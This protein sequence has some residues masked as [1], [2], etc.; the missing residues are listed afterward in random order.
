MI[1]PCHVS[2]SAKAN[3]YG[4]NS[5]LSTEKIDN[6]YVAPTGDKD[7]YSTTVMADGSTLDESERTFAFLASN[8]KPVENTPDSGTTFTAIQS[9]PAPTKDPADNQLWFSTTVDEVDILI[10]PE[11]PEYA[12]YFIHKDNFGGISW[13]TIET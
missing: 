1:S 2:S 11:V 9:V 12:R 10:H 7:D 6:L 8:W 5:D 13:E 3:S 4:S